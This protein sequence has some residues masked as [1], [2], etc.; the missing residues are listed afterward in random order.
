MK[1]NR[2][3][4]VWGLVTLFAAGLALTA[5]PARACTVFVLTDASH[6]L[7]CNNEDWHE[8]KANIWFHPAKKG[9]YGA[10]YLGFDNGWP[11]G[12]LNTEGLAYDWVLTLDDPQKWT[13][14]LPTPRGHSTQRM[15][16]TCATVKEAIAFYRTY[17]ESGFAVSKLLIADRTG[18]S[19]ILGF[20]DGQLAVAESKQSRGFGFCERG[21][22]AAALARPAE[23]TVDEG[24][25]ILYDCRQKGL[26]ETKYQN[27]FDLKTGDISLRALLERIVEVKLNLAEELKKGEHTYDMVALPTQLK[28][29]PRPL[30]PR[31]KRFPMDEYQPIPDKEPQVT[32]RVGKMIRDLAAGS[33]H[34]EDYT[35]DY[36]KTT[37]LPMGEAAQADLKRGGELES[38]T[39]VEREQQQDLRIYRYRFDFANT[40]AIVH[41]AIDA[42]DKVAD[43]SREVLEGKA[44]PVKATGPSGTGKSVRRKGR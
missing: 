5:R 10:V 35:T 4:K 34:A 32:A 39:L 12:G 22:L 18:A 15:L 24:M 19:A 26:N 7:F 33:P 38:M 17:A 41:L 16:E 29:A 6:A 23:P 2:N 27:V 31:M 13:S 43:F 9:F 11:Q 30:P 42:Q 37:V 3:S 8:S 36:W 1:R 14:D 20:K 44:S 28:Q 25:T 21:P 40:R